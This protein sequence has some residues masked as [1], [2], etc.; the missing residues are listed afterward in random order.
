MSEHTNQLSSHTRELLERLQHIN[1]TKETQREITNV[2]SVS[3]LTRGIEFIYE[4][5]RNA[6]E[7][8]EEHLWLK[9]A[10]Y[11]ILSRRSDEII[12]H[13]KIG[14]EF[15]EELIRGRYLENNYWPESK[16]IEVDEILEKYRRVIE[17]LETETSYTTKTIKI[18]EQ[19]LLGIAAVELENIFHTEQQDRVFINYF[20]HSIKE[21]LA[22]DQELLSEEL[23]QQLYLA[24]FRN[25]LQADIMMEHFELFRLKYPTWF[26]NPHEIEHDI[27]H[28]LLTIK[29]DLEMALRYPL[30]KQLDSLMKRRGLLILMLKN[31]IEQEKENSEQVLADPEILETKLKEL[32]EARYRQGREK[33]KTAAI[34]AVFFIIL[35]KMTLLFAIEIPYQIWHEGRLNYPALLV[36]MFLPPL[37]LIGSSFAI[38]MPG[39]EQN[40]LR[41]VS[42]FVKIIKQAD[43]LFALD[44]IR[45]P[46]KRSAP[47]Q[48]ALGTLYGLNFVFTGW[49]FYLLFHFL[50][51]NII[52]AFIFIFFLSLVNFFAF[53]LRKTTNELAAIEQKDHPLTMLLELALMPTVE[54]GRILSQGLS[55]IN[56]AAFIFDFLLETP[57]K[58]I[59]A[60][61]EE[62]FVFVKERKQK[63]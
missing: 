27:G 19:W 7:Y 51:F 26:T 21:R 52:D 13:E 62:W 20:W 38:K 28:N 8:H 22:I 32:Y 36:N 53:R 57:F 55:R 16:A 44:V 10:I 4:K 18:L 34:R 41:V 23:D 17:I 42:D 12:A 40:F 63:L 50:H 59:T 58:S 25:F 31:L 9:N 5:I 3:D 14:R 30:R 56:V 49:L 1:Q 2:I 47:V 6:L 61:L 39:E 43:T 15:I 45:L 35:T 11:R 46:K 24:V 54:L 48:F 33:L 37:L 29:Q 60:I